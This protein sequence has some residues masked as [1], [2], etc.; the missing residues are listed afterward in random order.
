MKK[1]WSIGLMSGTSNDGKIDVAAIRT[2][3]E[4]ILEFGPYQLF[5]MKIR[6]LG[7]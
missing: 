5:L 3:G 1:D 7:M 6:I 2:D 4:K